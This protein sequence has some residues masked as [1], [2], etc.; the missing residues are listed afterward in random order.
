LIG[1]AIALGGVV[2]DELHGGPA[3]R[4]RNVALDS[5]TKAASYDICKLRHRALLA[6][7]FHAHLIIFLR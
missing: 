3:E 2:D 1:R 5:G 6:R 7:A 4:D